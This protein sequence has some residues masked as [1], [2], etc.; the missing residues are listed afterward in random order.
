M[1]YVLFALS[2]VFSAGC[3]ALYGWYESWSVLWKLPLL[4]V[5]CFVAMV[6]LFLLVLVVSC[7]FV[8]PKKPLETPSPYF[9]FLLNQFSKL[10][11]DLGGVRVHAAGLERVPR[12]GRFLLVSNHLFAFDPIVF[13]YAMPWAELAFVSKTE[14]FSL[15]IVAQVMRKIL[16]LPLDRNNDREALKAILK[17]IQFLKEDK[18][19]I[20][21]FPE[22][23]TNRTEEDLLPF[24][25]GAFKVAQKANVPIVICALVNSKA[26]LKNMF[27]RHTDVY[28][29]VL[30]VIPP[31]QFAEQRTVEV[32]D[33]AHRILLEGLR[34][35]K[36]TL[37][38]Q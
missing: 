35:R 27:R 25:N 10:A 31:E 19:S 11:F 20:A 7:L 9:R 8:D 23:G 37:A 26:I 16:C 28:L 12:E 17:A 3:S 21:V 4:C 29:D 5:G 6:L 1:V 24:R 13:Y 30:D 22:G 18:A 32:G 15:P 36:A 38:A 34:K 33:R 14:N 2:A